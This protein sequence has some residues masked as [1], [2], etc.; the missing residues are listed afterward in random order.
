MN[1]RTSAAILMLGLAASSHAI[2]PEE[3]AERILEYGGSRELILQ[4]NYA[5]DMETLGMANAPDPRIEGEY[6]IAPA[7]EDNRW[8]VGIGYEFD[9][10]GAYSA[11]GN[12]GSA[13]RGQN[14]S[15]AHADLYRKKADILNTIWTWLYADRKLDLMRKVS[16]T[17]DS[18]RVIAA[19]AERG[20][21]L[22]RL[23]ISKIDIEHS[24]INSVIAGIENE[25]L[26]AEG[27]LNIL[28]GGTYCNELLE[29]I[30]CDWS[31][32]PL[33][34]LDDYKACAQNNPLLVNA[35]CGVNVADKNIAVAK[36]ERLPG[37]SVG[38]SHEYEDGMHFNGANLGIS[39]PIFS[40]RNKVKA[41][42]AAK[43]V[44]EMERHNASL[45]MESDV[46]ALYNEVVAL[47]KSI[48][49]PMAVFSS[50]DYAEMLLK[51]YR[52]GEMSL[53]EY[54]TELSWFYEAHLEFMDLQYQRESKAAQLSLISSSVLPILSE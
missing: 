34:G 24:R 35:I 42:Q 6:L 7:G 2:T 26:S 12:L 47:D 32:T 13:I 14:A 51:A 19:K 39:I 43:A 16:A 29:S 44:A 23:D 15:Q 46:I 54:L 49:T 9:W 33:A 4:N 48:A 21:E 37:F 20:G 8:G 10:P 45:Q 52:G 5:K 25:K 1:I 18:I 50:T 40:S 38:Y 53:A 28:F 36:S 30:A 41:A 22:S 11:R 31:A 3:A 17:N 27:Q